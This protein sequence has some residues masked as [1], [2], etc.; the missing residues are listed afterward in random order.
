MTA[1]VSAVLHSVL[2][3]TKLKSVS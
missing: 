3:W 1:S 2:Y